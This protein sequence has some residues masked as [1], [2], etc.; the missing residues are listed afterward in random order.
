[1]SLV[2]MP[3]PVKMMGN[4]GNVFKKAATAPA[5]A[6]AAPFKKKPKMPGGMKSAMKKVLM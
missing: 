4:I 3:N 1:M 6:M 2:K 5:N